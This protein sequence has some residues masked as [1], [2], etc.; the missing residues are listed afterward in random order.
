MSKHV[1][2][3]R[4]ASNEVC[5]HDKSMLFLVS[6]LQNIFI[7]GEF[8]SQVAFGPQRPG[9]DLPCYLVLLILCC[10]LFYLG[11]FAR[12]DFN[13]GML[14]VNRLTEFGKLPLPRTFPWLCKFWS[15]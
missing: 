8:V 3:N 7:K 5:S 14:S 6:S 15:Q 12:V 11:N 1:V 9:K 13:P 4:I 10:I 2:R